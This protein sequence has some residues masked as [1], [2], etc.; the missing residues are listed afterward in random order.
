MK[1]SKQYIDSLVNKL[2]KETLEDKANEVMEKL[3]FKPG[4]SFDY[5]QEGEVC[6]CGG[7]IYEGECMECGMREGEMLETKYVTSKGGKYEKEKMPPS[8]Q[9]IETSMSMGS[10]LEEFCSHYYNADLPECQAYY[11]YNSDSEI[12][13]RL[14][15]KQSRLDK[16]KNGRL[17]SEDFKMLRRKKSEMS[18][19]GE[20]T[21][22]GDKWEMGESKH[23][24]QV[25]ETVYRLVDGNNSELFTENE[26]IDIIEGIV[27]EEKKKEDNIKKGSTPAGYREYEKSYKGS[28]K[29][30][31]EYLDSV[32][33]KLTEYLKD[34]S[35]SKFTTT[36]KHFPKGNG[37]LEKMEK[38]AYEVS[39]DG[40]EFI[41]DYLR[42]GMQ[43][44]DYDEMHPNEEWMND[45][46]EGS[47]RT[48]NNSEWG[49]AETTEVNKKINKT[50][51]KGA[52]NKAKRAA[53]NKAPQ[54]VITDKPGQES[55]KGLHIKTES[56]L[57]KSQMKLNEEF[58]RMKGLIT[59][60]RKT[61]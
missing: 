42:P 15:G 16:N 24:K 36:P 20:C 8:R 40:E 43:T 50:R 22:C 45:N 48:G 54:P 23:K 18:E 51:K 41:D 57:D 3:N 33:K 13:E 12:D 47:S 53:Y 27:K 49:N 9:D 30:N 58:D 11:G 32:A 26:I 6:E 28:G 61:Q 31:K 7:S 1:N 37:E 52:Y 5:V 35:K 10:D 59:Y 60:N 21:E 4:K 19:E 29:E 2:L 55:G 38:K 25:E 34:G 46:I 56:T 44:L 14:Y 39:K 17:D